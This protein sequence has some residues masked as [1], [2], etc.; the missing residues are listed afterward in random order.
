M[1][2]GIRVLGDYEPMVSRRAAPPLD[3]RNVFFYS[4]IDTLKSQDQTWS[5]R[6]AR[7]RMHQP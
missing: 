4:R 1:L 5:F 7:F 2:H 6:S 3:P